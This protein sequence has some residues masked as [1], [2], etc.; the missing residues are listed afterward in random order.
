[1]VPLVEASRGRLITSDSSSATYEGR[2]DDYWSIIGVPNGGYS[3]GSANACVQDYLANHLRSS[4]KDLYHAASTFL[5][6]VEADKSWTLAI[7]VMKAGRNFSNIDATLSQKV[8]VCRKSRNEIFCSSAP[9][10]S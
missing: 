3:F 6:A 5:N 2:F 10:S 7:Q 9:V 4:H 1:M 8:S